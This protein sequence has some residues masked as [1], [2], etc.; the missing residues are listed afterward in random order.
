MTEAEAETASPV[1]AESLADS[2][3][4]GLTRGVLWVAGT[5]DGGV[6]VVVVGTEPFCVFSARTVDGEP[7]LPVAVDER[8]NV[9]G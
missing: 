5:A 3:S 6:A 4:G 8:A 1:G 7:V 9:C 2:C